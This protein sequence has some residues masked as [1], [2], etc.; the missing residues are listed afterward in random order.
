MSMRPTIEQMDLSDALESIAGLEAD[1]ARAHF[2]RGYYKGL[3]AALKEAN[4]SQSLQEAKTRI[5]MA[6]EPEDK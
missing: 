2:E 5:R 4:Q 1:L 6:P 3:L